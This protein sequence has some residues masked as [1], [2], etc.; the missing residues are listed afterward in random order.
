MLNCW[1]GSSS[2]KRSRHWSQSGSVKL[3]YLM[4]C[5]GRISGSQESTRLKKSYPHPEPKEIIDISGGIKVSWPALPPSRLSMGV[6]VSTTYLDEHCHEKNFPAQ[7]DQA[8]SYPWFPRPHGYR[9]RPSRSQGPSCQGP[10]TH[11]GTVISRCRKPLV[12]R[13]PVMPGRMM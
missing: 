6:T 8:R 12:A 1:G 2:S 13:H 7:Q 9:R 3:N 5:G 11:F 4:G 10:C